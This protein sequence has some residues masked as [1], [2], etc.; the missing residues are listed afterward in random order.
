MALKKAKETEA[1]LV[2]ATDPDADRVGI[3]VRDSKGEFVLLNG[4]QTA[5]LLFF[6]ILS[7]KKQKNLITGRDYIVTTIVTTELLKDMAKRFGV[8]YFEVLTGF[9]FIAEVIRKNEGNKTFIAGG[10]ESYGYLV[11]DFVRDKD[12]VSACAMIAEAAA[13]MADSQR[14]LFDLLLNIY[15][16]FAFYKEQLLSVTKKG[17]KGEEEI[18]ELMRRYREHPFTRINNSRV[19]KV[20]DYLSLR[21]KDLITGLEKEIDLP[22]SDVL[23]FILEDGSRIS[24]RPSGTE[25]K[26]K[27]YFGVREPLRNI[28]EFGKIEEILDQKIRKIIAAMQV[29]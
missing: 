23:Q 21:E 25:P 22:V 18:R 20:K 1:D 5:A 28:A 26:I 13:F 4:N 3:A 17:K 6:Y 7:Q 27:Y 10:E 15:R 29:T 24:V 11:S 16:D 19:V 8:G 14:S 2:M 12:A 9:K